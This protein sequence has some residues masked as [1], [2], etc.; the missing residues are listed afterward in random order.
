MQ[1][2]VKIVDVVFAKLTTE[3]QFLLVDDCCCLPREIS[4]VSCAFFGDVETFGHA[5][6]LL[7]WPHGGR[8]LCNMAWDRVEGKDPSTR[9]A[10]RAKDWSKLAFLL[11]VLDLLQGGL[12]SAV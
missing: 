7:W 6:R 4:F 8:T 10:A 2:H 5:A 11:V 12:C 3:Q 9:T 1:D